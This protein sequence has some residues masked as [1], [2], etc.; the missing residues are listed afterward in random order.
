MAVLLLAVVSMPALARGPLSDEQVRQSII[1]ESIAEYKAT[2]HP[3]AC[4][5]DLARNGSIV[6]R[7]KRLQPPRWCGAALL[8][9]G[10]Q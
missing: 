3:C 5:Y 2:G 10:R 9:V 7:E 4:P 6:W 1:Q 8:S